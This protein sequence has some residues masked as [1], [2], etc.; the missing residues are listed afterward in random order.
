[1]Y[2]I[3]YIHSSVDGHLGCFLILAIVNNAAMNIGVHVS[4][5]ISVF[6]SEGDIPRSGIA[7]LHGSS[8]FSF[9]GK[10]HTVFHSDCTNLHFHQPTMYKGF[11]FSTSSPTFVIYVLFYD[12]HSDRCEVISQYGFDSHFPDD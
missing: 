12:N 11:L 3:I 10:L 7:G 5:Q 4:F 9:L 6:L 1:M 8:I 2:Y